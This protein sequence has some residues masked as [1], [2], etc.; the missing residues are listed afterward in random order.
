MRGS[1]HRTDR[2]YDTKKPMK[3][4]DINSIKVASPCSVPWGSMTGDDRSRHCGQCSLTVF[5][6][7]ELTA[8]ETERLIREREGRLCIRLYR[9]A[10]GTVITRD[11]PTGLR[12][13]RRR[14]ARVASAAFAAVLGLVT[15]G[16]GQKSEP[17]ENNIPIRTVRTESPQM[18]GTV[19]GVVVDPTGAVIP[20]AVVNVLTARGT[21]RATTDSDGRFVI[22]GEVFGDLQLTVEANGF[23]KI[24][25]TVPAL[26][27][28][29]A[30]EIGLSMDVSFTMG[31]YVDDYSETIDVRKSSVTTT[32]SN[33]KLQSLPFE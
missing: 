6:I 8:A 20:G 28:N 19:R 1:A 13:V 27:A 25:R 3:K 32:I 15:I 18:A 24:S 29:E 2:Q 11:C 21:K 9:R 31:I 12:A 33:R 30:L 16:Y 17:D 14:L 5:N 4:F 26:G 22:P 7:A 23:R 10:D